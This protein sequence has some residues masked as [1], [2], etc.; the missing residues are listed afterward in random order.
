MQKICAFNSNRV[1][2]TM[3]RQTQS[4]V[5]PIGI[6]LP[7]AASNTAWQAKRQKT[8]FVTISAIEPILKVVLILMLIFGHFSAPCTFFGAKGCNIVLVVFGADALGLLCL[9]FTLMFAMAWL[10]PIMNW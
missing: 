5:V 8:T 9:F 4:S 3:N 1:V 6:R 2:K 7:G 10:L